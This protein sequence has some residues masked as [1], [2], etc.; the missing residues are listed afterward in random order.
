MAT[1]QGHQ[2]FSLPPLLVRDSTPSNPLY[3]PDPVSPGPG[4]WL[5]MARGKRAC[6]KESQSTLCPSQARESHS[7][8]EKQQQVG[9]K[10]GDH[11]G[12]PGMVTQC[13]L[14]P[15]DYTTISVNEQ[16]GP[17]SALC[18][19]L[20][21]SWARAGQPCQER[22]CPSLRPEH[23][24]D[25]ALLHSLPVLQLR[26]PLSLLRPGANYSGFLMGSFLSFFF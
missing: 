9:N 14:Q 10:I 6:H 23:S 8:Q 2:L 7:L 12:F 18:S 15:G 25:W 21:G 17:K 19:V 20:G 26:M 3:W 5:R 24:V 22:G 11:G 4:T 1:L 16:A 13:A